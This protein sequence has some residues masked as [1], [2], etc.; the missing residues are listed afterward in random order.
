M[1]WFCTYFDKNYMVR[2]LALYNSLTRW[3]PD[4]RLCVVCLDKESHNALVSMNLPGILAFALED[5][6]KY[7]PDLL[8]ARSNRNLLEYYYTLTPMINL[9]VF[10]Q[11]PEVH[12]VTYLKQVP[13]GQ[14]SHKQ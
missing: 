2:G 13:V 11:F 7:D 3:S 1:R 4:F 14:R 8:A 9:F 5:L 12:L 6:E 10:H